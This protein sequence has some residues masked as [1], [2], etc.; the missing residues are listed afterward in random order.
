MVRYC[1]QGRCYLYYHRQEQTLER[2][3]SP[4]MQEDKDIFRLPYCKSISARYSCM[5]DIIIKQDL[6]F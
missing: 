6:P 3:A 2:P 1:A 5:H 4:G